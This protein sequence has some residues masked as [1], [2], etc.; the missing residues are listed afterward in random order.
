MQDASAPD[1]AQS[2]LGP[3]TAPERFAVYSRGF[4]SDDH[5]RSIGQFVGEYVRVFSR[6]FDLSHLDGVTVAY[7]YAQALRDLDRGYETS[8]HLTPSEG[9]AVGVAMTPSVLRDGALKSH[10]VLNAH[11][12]AAILNQEH[13]GF[14]L[15]LHI[16]AHECAHVEI[17][18]T[19]EAAFPGVL[20]RQQYSDVRIA[21]RQQVILAC[22]DEY[23]ATSLSAGIGED[24]TDGYE[25]T[26]LRHLAEARQVANNHIKQYRIHASVDRVLAEVY[27]TYGNL[28]KFAAYHLGNL[29]G[30]GIAI[31]DR[32]RTVEALA[33]HWFAPY[34]VQLGEACQAIA[35]SYGRWPDQAPFEAIGDI[36]DNLVNLGGVL[37][38]YPEPGQLYIDIPFTADTIPDVE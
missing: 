24:P 10:I 33:G 38:R 3:P 21:F 19:F 23:A 4:E 37:F 22:W 9:H 31:A 35:N 28:L 17:T 27:G 6:R 15:A 30:Q 12:V 13:E 8:H 25:D 11:F 1:N 2:Q 34:F 32:A 5:A 36:A 29:D 26:F 16:I 7:D 14:R 20:L 18:T